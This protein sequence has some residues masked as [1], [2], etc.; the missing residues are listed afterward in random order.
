MS[1][2]SVYYFESPPLPTTQLC[3]PEGLQLSNICRGEQLLPSISFSDPKLWA[4][5]CGLLSHLPFRHFQSLWIVIWANRGP[6]VISKMYWIFVSWFPWFKCDFS[7]TNRQRDLCYVVSGSMFLTTDAFSFSINGIDFFFFAFS[8]FS[9]WSSAAWKAAARVRSQPVSWR[10]CSPRPSCI[11]TM[12]EKPRRRSQQPTP[13]SLSG[14]F[15]GRACHLPNLPHCENY[16]GTCI[17]WWKL[18]LSSRFF[19]ISCWEI[20]LS[21]ILLIYFYFLHLRTIE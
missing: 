18:C 7:E 15:S 10:R 1:L 17:R 5:V 11:S 19:D 8:P 6:L 13:T 3:F 14:S 12:S 4:S 2:F 16:L 9:S 20:R 21:I